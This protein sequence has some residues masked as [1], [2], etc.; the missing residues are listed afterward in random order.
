MWSDAV[1]EAQQRGFSVEDCRTIL[2]SIAESKDEAQTSTT[3]EERLQ[4]VKKWLDG[5]LISPEEA[6]AKRKAILPPWRGPEKKT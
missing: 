1:E 4:Q 2:G 5:G 3:A 6:A